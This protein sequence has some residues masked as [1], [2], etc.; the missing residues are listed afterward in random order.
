MVLSHKTFQEKLA[1]TS[2]I[3]SACIFGVFGKKFKMT[4]LI[5]NVV[6]SF[7]CVKSLVILYIYFLLYY[8]IEQEAEEK[9]KSKEASDK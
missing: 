9:E 4:E 2:K 3:K 8:F 6:I 7:L 5:E 1:K